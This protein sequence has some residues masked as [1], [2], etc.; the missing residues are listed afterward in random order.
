M[1]PFLSDLRGPIMNGLLLGAFT[2]CG[3]RD[4]HDF[5]DR[6]RRHL[7]MGISSSWPVISALSPCPFSRSAPAD[8]VLVIP[9]MFLIDLSFNI[10]GE[11]SRGPG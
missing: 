5:R 3:E 2:D 4:V 9:M 10:T 8:L 1:I 11:P 7:A 6:A